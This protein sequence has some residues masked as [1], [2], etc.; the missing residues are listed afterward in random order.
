MESL[1]EILIIRGK[2]YQYVVIFLKIIV[3]YE[4]QMVPSSIALGF[5]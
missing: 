3:F 4:F 2:L 5:L 1:L